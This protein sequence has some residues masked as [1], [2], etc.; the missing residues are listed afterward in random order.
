MNDLVEIVKPSMVFLES[1]KAALSKGWSPNTVRPEAAAEELIAISNDPDAFIS[2]LTDL[3]AIGSPIKLPDGSFA[4]RLPGF[5]KWIW[6]GEFCGVIGFRWKP[7]TEELPPHVLGHVGYSVVPWK[8]GQGYA[9]KALTELVAQ[10]GFTDLR[11]I[12]ISTDIDNHASQRVAENCG[13][14]FYEEFDKPLVYKKTKGY[15][16]RIQLK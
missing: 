11:H 1:Y 10:I 16:Y 4:E 6:D 9:T 15:R 3:E 14:V 12:T 7:G 13:A 8:R 2:S 5:I